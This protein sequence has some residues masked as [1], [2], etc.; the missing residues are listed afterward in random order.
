MSWGAQYLGP[1]YGMERI[2][3][4]EA[5][6]LISSGFA[7]EMK[8]MTVREARERGLVLVGEEISSGVSVGDAINADIDRLPRP[9]SKFV[10][11]TLDPHGFAAGAAEVTDELI[12]AAGA[13]PQPNASGPFSGFPFGLFQYPEM[14]R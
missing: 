5:R 14:R 3:K 8:E 4:A 12:G 2:S 10:R 6:F 7:G 1:K 13:R 9:V 11:K